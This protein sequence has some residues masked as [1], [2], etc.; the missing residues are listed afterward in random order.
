MRIGKVLNACF[1]AGF[2]KPER[3]LEASLT[4]LSRFKDKNVA[5]R[6]SVGFT[7]IVLAVVIRL[8]K[9]SAHMFGYAMI[10]FSSAIHTDM[11]TA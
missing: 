7:H 6:S 11:K 1:Q 3:V 4:L 8:L 2:L 10:D 9:E 5:K